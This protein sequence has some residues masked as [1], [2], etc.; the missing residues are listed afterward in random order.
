MNC[1]QRYLELVKKSLLNELYIELEAQLIFSV[2][3]ATH[4]QQLD[5][6][7]FRRARQDN[8]LLN[9]IASAKAGGDTITL[10]GL[11]EHKRVVP[12]EQF[13]NYIEYA[14]TM[15]GRKRLD[16]LQECVETVLDEAVPGD[17][18]ETGVWRGGSCIL[19]KAVLAVRGVTD[20]RVWA[21]DSFQGLPPPRS[22]QDAGLDMTK[23]RFP[24]LAVSKKEVKALFDRYQLLDEQVVFIE[25]WF[26]DTVPKM[27]VDEI[28]VL[29]IDGDLYES[30]M[31][32]L[33]GLYSKVSR[34][35]FVVIDDYH[36]LPPC[37]QAVE[38]FRREAE[39]TV[40]LQD[41]DNYGVFWRKP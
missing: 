20:R 7:G 21:V 3:C 15:I 12:Q 30:T 6:D 31:D 28:A 35:G 26:R 24:F 16:H 9:A 41:I 29:R 34:G 5:L 27:A 37:A 4:G 19:M 38:D 23:E 14:H 32:A 2:L 33:S 25:G 13:R 11:D 18:V 40:P 36:I 8:G 1:E 10:Q 39:I 22:E 17:L